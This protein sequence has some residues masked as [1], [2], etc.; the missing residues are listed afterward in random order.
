MS[1]TYRLGVDLG[2]TF[3]AAAYVRDGRHAM[4]PLGARRFDVPTTVCIT[5]DGTVH[6]GEQAEELAVEHPSAVAR[7]FKRRLGDPVPL[8]V[9]GRPY[10]PQTLMAQVLRWTV[11]RAAEQI[12][13]LPELVTVTCPANWGPYKHELLRQVIKLAEV[14]ATIV[15]SEPEAAAIRH[16]GAD[17]QRS[18][19]LVGVYDWGG[20]T[21]DAAVLRSSGTGV[22]LLA[23]SPEGIEHLGGI[24][25]DE[26]LNSHVLRSLGQRGFDLASSEDPTVL[27]ALAA[28]RRRCVQ[29]KEELSSQQST[30]V[31]V[32][33]DGSCTTVL[34]TRQELEAM[35]RPALADTVRAFERAVRNAGASPDQ[36]TSVVLVGGSARIPLVFEAISQSIECQVVVP[37]EPGHSVALGAAMAAERYRIPVRHAAT[38]T[39][40]RP[41]PDGDGVRPAQVVRA[42]REATVAVRELL[43][44]PPGDRATIRSWLVPDGGTVALGQ[45]LASVRLQSGASTRAVALRSPFEGVLHRH[46]LEPGAPLDGDDLLSAFRDVSAYLYRPARALPDDQGLIVRIHPPTSVTAITGRPVVFLDREPRAVWWSAR[47][48]LLAEP[49][50]HTMSVAYTRRDQWFGFATRHVEVPAGGLVH[51]DYTDPG[52]GATAGLEVVPSTGARVS[53]SSAA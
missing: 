49:G 27:A 41:V 46:F 25:V 23:G 33:V 53:S 35:I 9:G 20:G 43:R 10:S 28:V 14:P 2:T 24:D 40:S 52:F 31:E 8:I 1:P 26:A 48:C 44:L 37:R 19:A 13:G 7:E 18:G 3:T 5:P 22:F 17:A 16:A 30:S 50:P 34:V 32:D 39:R 15:C 21:F 4:V 29:A 12:G 45:P 36:L 42:P 6:V 51:L 47:F 38:R 11:S